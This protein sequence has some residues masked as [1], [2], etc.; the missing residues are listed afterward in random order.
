MN[1]KNERDIF[2]DQIDSIRELVESRMIF[3]K[4]EDLRDD[5]VISNRLKKLKADAEVLIQEIH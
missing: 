3:H 1:K 2:L 5:A 4:G